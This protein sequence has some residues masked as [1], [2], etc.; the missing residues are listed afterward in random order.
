MFL[1]HRF[2]FLLLLAGFLGR[3]SGIC[4]N[5]VCFDLV[6]RIDQVSSRRGGG[7]NREAATVTMMDGSTCQNQKLAAVDISLFQGADGEKLIDVAESLKNKI[8]IILGV[9]SKIQADG[10][11]SLTSSYGSKIMLAPEGAEE[12]QAMSALAM[13][14]ETQKIAEH[15]GGSGGNRDWDAEAFLVT[16]NWLRYMDNAAAATDHLFQVNF[17]ALEVPFGVDS[18]RT[19]DGNRLWFSTQLRDIT[20]TVRVWVSEE[21]ALAVNADDTMTSVQFEEAWKQQDLRF[22]VANVKVSCA[23]VDGQMQLTVGRARPHDFAWAMGAR[24]MSAVEACAP[25]PPGATPLIPCRLS[26]IVFA[27]H[28]GLG[29]EYVE[30]TDQNQNET[31]WRFGGPLVCCVIGTKRSELKDVGH[32]KAITNVCKD[33]CTDLDH[34]A[35]T[36]TLQTFA[37]ENRQTDYQLDKRS[38]LVFVTGLTADKVFIVEGMQLL[39]PWMLDKAKDRTEFSSCVRGMCVALCVRTHV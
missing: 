27:E 36:Y 15:T 16:C 3:S 8:V 22:V 7:T 21:A 31:V 20:G 24:A 28:Q 5:N 2:I 35:A 10:A 18:I 23:E 19:K 29:A 9:R 17:A 30:P 37:E 25:L 38:A 39:E 11:L 4:T 26:E 33:I 12:V 14:G 34:D 13:D 32:G 6:G 1:V